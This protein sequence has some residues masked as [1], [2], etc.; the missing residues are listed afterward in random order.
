MLPHSAS[1]PSTYLKAR[2]D[3]ISRRSQCSSRNTSQ[4]SGHKQAYGT[5]AARVVSNGSFDVCI[6]RE[7]DGGETDVTHQARNFPLVETK[8]SKATGNLKAGKNL[9]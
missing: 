9:S 4:G 1:S 8:K 2:F 7:V 5:I 6:G 3:Y